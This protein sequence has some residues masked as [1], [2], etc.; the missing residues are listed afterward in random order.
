MA[1]TPIINRRINDRR[2]YIL[3]AI[4]IPII[5]LI[6]FARTYYLKGF[7]ARSKLS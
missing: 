6:G 5:V 7:F 4:L 1:A 2:L 3:A